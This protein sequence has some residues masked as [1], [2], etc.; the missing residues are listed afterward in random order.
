MLKMLTAYERLVGYQI[1]IGSNATGEA[2]V[3][4]LAGRDKMT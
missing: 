2:L 1:D 4:H 3:K